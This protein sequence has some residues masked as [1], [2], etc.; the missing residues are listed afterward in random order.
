MI[1]AKAAAL[2]GLTES[3]L[4]RRIFVLITSV[5]KL[6]SPNLQPSGDTDLP[7]VHRSPSWP[8]RARAR[9]DARGI[10][11]FG[12]IRWGKAKCVPLRSASVI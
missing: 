10:A 11:E 8:F 4:I 12:S 5:P 9:A 1:P 6:W 7:T 3:K 2:A